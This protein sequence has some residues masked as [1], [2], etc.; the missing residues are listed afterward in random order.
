MSSSFVSLFC[1]QTSCPP[2]ESLLCYGT[3]EL[4][5]EQRVHIAAHLSVCEFCEAELQLLTAHRPTEE[6]CPAAAE[7]PANLRL[8]A[9]A[10][11][12]RSLNRVEIYA[13]V[14]YEKVPLTLTDA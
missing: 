12:G 14:A 5:V 10:I 7:M 8:L 1:K 9:E 6:Q 4:S 11:L 3:A 13:E 2:A